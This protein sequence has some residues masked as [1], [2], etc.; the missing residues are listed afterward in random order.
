MFKWTC[1]SVAVVFGLLLVW[2]VNDMRLEIRKSV[3]TVNND[4]PEIVAKSREVTQIVHVN[5]PELVERTKKTTETLATL[6]EDVQQL[7]KLAGWT[8]GPRDE[9][10]T[11]YAIDLLQFIE[12]SKGQIGAKKL[13]GKGLDDPRPAREWARGAHREA[14]FDV[15]VRVRSKAELL[16][17]LGKTKL[18]RDWYMR[19]DGKETPL[20]EWIKINHPPSKDLDKDAGKLPPE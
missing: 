8:T 5:L 2:M 13:V 20:I 9:T 11:S 16:E 17:R 1:L 4:L 14:M 7:R 18:G 6:S 12:D 19:I 10:L 15:L 3:Q